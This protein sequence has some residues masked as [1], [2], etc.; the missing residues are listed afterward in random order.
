MQVVDLD[1]WQEEEYEDFVLSRPTAL[2][3]QSLRFR[4]FLTALIGC[5]PRYAVA[6]RS[7]EV[8]GAMP[9]MATDGPYGVV[10]NSLPYFGSNGGIL[11][12]DDEAGRALVDW[13]T[14]QLAQPRVAAGTVIASPLE[15]APPSP[16][17]CDFDDARVGYVTSL[18]PADDPGEQ[19]LELIDGSARRNVQK[20]LRSGVTVAIENG[21]LSVLEALHVEN[22]T[23]IGGRAKTPDFFKRVSEHFRPGEEYDLYVA[24]LDGVAV[25]ALLLFYYSTTVE[26]YVP[27][28]DVEFR[29]LQ[30]MAAMLHRAMADATARG[31]TRWNWGGSWLGQ[32]T[33]MRFKAKWGGQP[34]RYNYWTRVN[35][36]DVLAASP[37]ELL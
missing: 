17:P 32:E 7:E 36:A 35:N 20:A 13:Y 5:E 26:Y 8:V 14:D 34:R 33:L 22:M 25:A 28:T 11:S 10:M 21:D 12:R 9:L 2:L 6:I 30:P 19:V 3:Y 15:D 37:E 4:D 1:Q 16:F 31:F 27:A 29:S 24:R 18:L 23:K